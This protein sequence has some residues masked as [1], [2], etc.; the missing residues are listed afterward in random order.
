M[1]QHRRPP[2][3][4]RPRAQRQQLRFRCPWHRLALQPR[5]RPRSHRR[6]D[7]H[8]GL[9][10]PQPSRG[11]Q[12]ALGSFGRAEVKFSRL[13]SRRTWSASRGLRLCATP[14]SGWQGQ[15][16]SRAAYQSLRVTKAPR[17]R[18]RRSIALR[19]TRPLPQG[20]PPR[21]R[22]GRRRRAGRQPRGARRSGRGAGRRSTAGHARAPGPWPPR[23]GRLLRL[24]QSP[25]Q[26][27]SPHPRTSCQPSVVRRRAVAREGVGGGRV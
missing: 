6:L 20:P 24:R 17:A 22:P 23:L 10:P 4:C 18:P 13:H 19:P 11:P 9:P 21:P 27:R 15:G 14:V 16:K 12:L 8:G 1:G 3:R 25:R 5:R 7:R 26:G 2:K